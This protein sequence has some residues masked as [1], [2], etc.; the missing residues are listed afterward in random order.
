MKE[1]TKR[2]IKNWLIVLVLLLDE[3]VAVA[4]V[5][6]ALWFFKISLPLWVA[7]VVA[8]LL[9]ACAFATHKLIIPSFHARQ[10]TG[11]EGM[12]GLVG[13]VI[14][15]LT[16]NGVITVEGEYWKARSVAGD[17]PAGEEVEVLGLD[18]LVLEVKCKKES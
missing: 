15:P 8:L 2:T 7:I 12:V 3:A 14:E 5:L 1:N 16:P 13:E 10:V 9:G 17:I 18:K 6:A 4:L 11:S